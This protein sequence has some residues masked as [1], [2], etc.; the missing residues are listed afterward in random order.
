MPTK[1]GRLKIEDL[2]HGRIAY[3]AVVYQPVSRSLDGNVREVGKGE[4]LIDIQ[5]LT[6]VG[7]PFRQ[8]GTGRMQIR[9]RDWE[10]PQYID[11]LLPGLFCTPRAAR[12]NVAVVL[13]TMRQI[14]RKTPKV[15][16][17]LTD[18]SDV[19]AK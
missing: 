10:E 17:R 15:Q 11:E 2:F 13:E 16:T 18:L 14:A 12:R 4:T 3:M 1:A 8:P 7:K 5:A 19:G 9:I 6:V